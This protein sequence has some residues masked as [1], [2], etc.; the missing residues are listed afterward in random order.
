MSKLVCPMCE[1]ELK[2]AGFYLKQYVNYVWDEDQ[3]RYVVED[4][5]EGEVL[6]RCCDAEL[7]DWVVPVQTLKEYYME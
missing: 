7:D 1:K 2:E 5:A 3:R 4:V 6:S